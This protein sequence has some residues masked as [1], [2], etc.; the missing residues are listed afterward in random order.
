M[1]LAAN[2]NALADELITATAKISSDEKEYSQ[3][4]KLK[5]RV[6]DALRTGSHA[7]TNQFTVSKQL[8]GLQEKFQVLNRDDLASALRVRLN[9]LE[10]SRNDWIP[11]ILSL[12]LQL[13]DRPALLSKVEQLGTLATAP[14]EAESLS[15]AHL[16]A[17]EAAF[18]DQDIWEEVN[19]AADSADDDLSPASSITAPPRP[20]SPT[21]NDL[22]EEY[23]IPEEAFVSDDEENLICAI[24]KSQFWNDEN[25]PEVPQNEEASRTVTEL[26]IAKEAIFML[27][28]LPTSIFWRLDEE[29]EIDRRY[30]ITYS[31]IETLTSWLRCFCKM[32]A[33]ID[34]VRQ[35]TKR[36]HDLPYMETLCRD[37]E[38][39]LQE[40]D[41]FLS[42]TQSY[43]VSAGST[44][45]L[46]KLLFDARRQSRSLVLFAEL[47][48]KL[49]QDTENEP[50]LCLDLLYDLVGMVEALGETRACRSLAEL[51]MSCFMTY[52]RSFRPW[53]EGGQLDPRN[54]PLFI[55]VNQ[56]NGNLRTLWHDWYVFD[57][58]PR[59]QNVPRFLENSIHKVFATGKNMVFLGHFK[60]F[61][62]YLI[63]FR[64]FYQAL[65]RYNPEGP[66][67]YP[68]PVTVQNAFARLVESIHSSSA[69]LLRAALDEHCELDISIDALHHIYL[70]KDL[71]VLDSFDAKVFDLM[72]RGRSWDD[73]FLLT[74]LARTVF[75]EVSF[76]NSSNIT[77][78][79][80]GLPSFHQ[81]PDNDRTVKSLEA[82]LIEFVLPWHIANII[83]DRD[84]SYYQRIAIFLMQIRRAKYALVKQR[85]RDARKA[86]PDGTGDTLTHILHHSLLSFLDSLYG[87]LTQCVIETATQSVKSNLSKT[88]DVDAMTS[89]HRFFIVSLEKQCLLSENL[90]PI[91]EAILNLL[92][93]CIHFADL[94]T[95]QSPEDE[96][97]SDIDSSDEED[98]DREQTLTVSLR[99]SPYGHQMRGVK[100]QFDHLTSFVVDGLKS[101]DRVEKRSSWGFL[102]SKLEWG[103]NSGNI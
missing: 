89:T 74:E 83:T 91:Y 53:M 81:P 76:I 39:K 18:S 29:V 97:D 96:I 33:K 68:F 21:S 72:D 101:L 71:S 26:Q 35:F 87:Y 46:I 30:T 75:K 7:R 95:A 78:R 15:W 100:H 16:D 6:E 52:T 59:E 50:M 45:S 19:F 47:V 99:D 12:I 31:S 49:G 27:Q 43:Y 67:R 32:A 36:R 70:G 42:Q 62:D 77:V 3:F 86:I 60:P 24:E 82:L 56:T 64:H 2:I 22:G 103:K 1:A 25:H 14:E 37:I 80:T 13:S 23:V 11:E 54:P 98:P 73:R 69:G 44:V 61:P 93:L 10:D 94:Q 92:D 65:E 20:R 79:S 58:G 90:S 5:C 66:P 88:R 85:L 9:E 63:N 84:I 40:F 38:N 17:K 28:G 51:F 102:A 57:E 55:R 41:T 4:K 34:V 48:T 8:E